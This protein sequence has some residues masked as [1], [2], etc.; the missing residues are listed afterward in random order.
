MLTTIY[1]TANE[2]INNFYMNHEGKSF[3]L[4]S[5]N[6]RKGVELFYKNG[7]SVDKAIH[8]GM[9]KKDKAIHR[10][11]DKLMTSIRYI[12]TESQI[13]VLRKTRKARRI[14]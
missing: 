3:Y 13:K 12:E 10:T 14:A 1:C 9:G 11:M 4:F 5:Q 7:V 6:R 8:H 2:N